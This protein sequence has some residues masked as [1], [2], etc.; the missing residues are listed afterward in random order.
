MLDRYKCQPFYCILAC[1]K[2]FYRVVIFYNNY[3]QA[4][5]LFLIH[6]ILF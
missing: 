3:N 6:P 2:K 5:F 4:D 1:K